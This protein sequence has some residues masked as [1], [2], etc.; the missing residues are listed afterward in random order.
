MWKDGSIKILFGISLLLLL[1]TVALPVV[2]AQKQDVYKF[3]TLMPMTGGAAWIGTLFLEGIDLAVNEI[4]AR[5]GV[6]GIKLEVVKEDHK[7]NPKDGSNA[8]A[9]LATLDKVPFVISSFTAVTLAAQPISAANKVLLVNTGGTSTQLLNKP[10]LYNNQVMTH[11]VLPPAANYFW[12]LGCRKLATVVTNDAFGQGVRDVMVDSWKKLGGEVVAG[13]LF[14]EGATDFSAQ[15]SK[16][17]VTKADVIASSLVGSTGVALMKQMRE[18]GIK[19]PVIDTPGDIPGMIKMGEAANQI[20]FAASYVDPDTKSPFARRYVDL[21]RRTYKKEPEAWNPATCYETVHIL[22]ELI[23]R[24]KNAGGNYR[25]GAEL[26]KALEKN[27][28]FPTVFDTKLIFLK[29]HGVLKQITLRE[30][31][32]RDGKL[33]IDVM[34]MIP[35]EAIPH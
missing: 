17:R 25:D 10:F 22:A 27:P 15:L 14:A 33:T 24:V 6:D 1:S 28:E 4:N 13:E 34:K 29:D 32:F 16:I 20:M 11:Q 19:Q 12:S 21:Y 18:L 9:K 3:G 35:I 30:G 8:M 7:G 31:K 26:V 2:H 5:G 23:K